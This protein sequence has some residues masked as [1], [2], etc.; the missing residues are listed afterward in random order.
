MKRITLVLVLFTLAG[1]ASAPPERSYYLLRAEVPNDLAAAPPAPAAG[2]GL[3]PVAAYLDRAGVVVEVGENQVRE[4]RFPLWAEPLDRGIRTYLSDR[5]AAQLGYRL[6]TG[7]G[8]VGPIRYRIDVSVEEFHGSLDG[9]TKLVARW[10]VRDLEDD[11]L[12]LSR[13]F[14]QQSR[15]SDDG[16]ASVVKS[17]LALLDDLAAEIAQGLTDLDQ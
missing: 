1:C 7:P 13:R 4:A 11:S 2:L 16:Y 3:F 15:Q 6:E 10:S 12:T 14:S 17:Q 9:E 8:S 5:I